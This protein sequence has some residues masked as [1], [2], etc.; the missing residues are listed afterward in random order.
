MEAL[1][2]TIAAADQ[3]RLNAY[4]A[5]HPEE[6]AQFEQLMKFDGAFEQAGQVSQIMM[7]VN[8]VGNVMTQI[9]A[10]PA[11]AVQARAVQVQTQ[12][13]LK[14]GV[15]TELSGRQIALIILL[16]SAAMAVLLALGGGALAF[17]SSLLQPQPAGALLRE[18]GVLLRDIFGVVMAL[19]RGVFTLPL[20]WVVLAVGGFAVVMWMARGGRGLD[21]KAAVGMSRT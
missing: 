17:G 10:M 8:F 15:I 5:T 1:D 4:L 16:C 14:A 2:G 20:A 9:Q 3:I 11:H 13:V 7:P 18:V 6:R 21:A 12:S 19:V